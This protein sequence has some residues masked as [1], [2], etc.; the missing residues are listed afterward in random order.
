MTYLFYFLPIYHPLPI[1]PYLLPATIYLVWWFYAYLRA[2]SFYSTVLPAWLPTHTRSDWRM[3]HFSGE[4]VW[5]GTGG[6]D[7]RL[8]HPSWGLL[9]LHW[10]GDAWGGGQTCIVTCTCSNRA[11]IFA[12]RLHHPPSCLL[13]TNMP[14][15]TPPGEGDFF[16]TYQTI[17]VFFSMDSRACLLLTTFLL[18]YACSHHTPTCSLPPGD[19]LSAFPHT[20]LLSGRAQEVSGGRTGWEGEGRLEPFLLHLGLPAWNGLA[21]LAVTG[22]LLP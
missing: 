22:G 5:A 7:S 2:S 3:I 9:S 4:D 12:H 13:P 11:C 18:P 21:G 20:S 19:T 8:S 16:S 6:R 10:E 14:T 1:I 15:T 17:S